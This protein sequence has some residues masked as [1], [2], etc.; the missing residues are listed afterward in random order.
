MN[1]NSKPMTPAEMGSKGGKNR[2]AK[3]PIEERKK[4]MSELGKIGATNR[5]AKIPKEERSEIMRK[6]AKGKKNDI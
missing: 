2:W 6:V 5:W 4:I 1:Q 3:V